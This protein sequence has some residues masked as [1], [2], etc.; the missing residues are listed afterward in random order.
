MD[1]QTVKVQEVD[2]SLA[3]AGRVPRTI[4][5][6]LERGLVD[7]CIPGRPNALLVLIVLIAEVVMTAPWL[8]TLRRSCYCRWHGE[9]HQRRACGRKVRERK[10]NSES[11]SPLCA[12]QLGG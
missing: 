7:T 5:V 10:G 1:Y 11:F 9:E 3:E 8:S 2:N 4:E 6:E 12:G